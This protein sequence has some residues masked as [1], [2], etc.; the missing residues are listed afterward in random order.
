MAGLNLSSKTGKGSA[1]SS[2]GES[3]EGDHYNNTFKYCY[4]TPCL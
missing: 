1:A 2:C 3:E 4:C